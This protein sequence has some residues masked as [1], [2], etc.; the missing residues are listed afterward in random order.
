MM[1]YI[2][3]YGVAL[4]LLLLIAGWLASGTLVQGG[5][6]PGNGEQAIID[7]I[8]AKEDGPVRQLFASLGLIADPD[9]IPVE[10]TE[11][12]EVEE[13]EDVPALQSVRIAH[14]SAQM[15]QVEVNVRG[16]TNA[17]ASVSVRA[18][19][20]GIVKQ[21]HVD[22]GAR[23]VPG[24]LLCTLDQGTRMARLAQGEAALAQAEAALVQSQANFETNAALREKGL[25][26]AN[27]A[28]QFE[29]GLTSAEASIRAAVSALDDIKNDLEKTSIYSEVSGIV[30]EPLANAGDVLNNSG[31]CATVVQMNPM[32]FAGKVAEA[33]IAAVQVGL[34]AYVTTV[35]GQTV[36]GVV[37][38]VSSSA[39][40][41]TRA[42]EIEIELDN[43]DKSLRDGITS[44]AKIEV[45]AIPAHLIPQS[46]LT[47]LTDGTL[48]VR[49]V[50][51]SIST[52]VPVTIINDQS[53]G[54]WVGGLPGEVDVI[55][56][57]QEN[58]TDGQQV[59]A[60]LEVA[61]N[62]GISS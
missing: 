34:T 38:Y 17:I 7:L 20:N 28:R 21:V 27:T 19:T 60:A 52:F 48:G 58:V 1:R 41:A 4:V 29:V 37:R 51:E 39:D 13:T 31:V 54:V 50:K 10:D 35:T 46:T 47:L 45:G 49:I 43:S 16:Q 36:E 23:V 18:E 32:L 57:G 55:I 22:K 14:F 56:L 61:G 5:K 62:G 3:S 12:I 25:A 15:M 2:M 26:A 6:G 42:F 11:T 33:K 40:R 30:Q 44:T 59:D 24:D 9:E 8:E 53:D